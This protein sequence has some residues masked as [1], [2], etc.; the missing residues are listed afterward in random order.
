MD[1]GASVKAGVRS[2]AGGSSSA[3]SAS[4]LAQYAPVALTGA[5]RTPLVETA[6]FAQNPVAASVA[7]GAMTR[8]AAFGVRTT[9]PLEGVTLPFEAEVT[10]EAPVVKLAVKFVV[11]VARKFVTSKWTQ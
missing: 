2:P 1:C 4:G 8:W 10:V 5:G 9:V 3:P 6:R 11:A 7:L